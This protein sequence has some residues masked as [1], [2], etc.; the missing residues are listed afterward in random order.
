MVQ[1]Y[2]ELN[3]VQLCLSLLHVKSEIKQA[4]SGQY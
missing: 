3:Y 1:N 2:N 4:R